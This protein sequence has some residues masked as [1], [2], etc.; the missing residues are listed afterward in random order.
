DTARAVSRLAVKH[1]ST[2]AE[3]IP[4]IDDLLRYEEPMML[5]EAGPRQWRDSDGAGGAASRERYPPEK[6]EG[7]LLLEFAFDLPAVLP[8]LLQPWT[9]LP[10]APVRPTKLL[11]ARSPPGRVAAAPRHAAAA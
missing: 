9:E 2:A 10:P 5:V 8:K 11:V 4:Y 3:P 1:D 6:V 7:T